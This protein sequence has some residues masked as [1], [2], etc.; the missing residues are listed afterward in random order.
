[1]KKKGREQ[2]FDMDIV[3]RRSSAGKDLIYYGVCFIS[4]DY[5]YGPFV[6]GTGGELWL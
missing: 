2:G 5:F 6:L 1:M 4:W 3:Y